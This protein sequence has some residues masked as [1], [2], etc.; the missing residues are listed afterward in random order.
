MQREWMTAMRRD[1]EGR[2]QDSKTAARDMR[3]RDSDG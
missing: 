1:G 2:K 3:H